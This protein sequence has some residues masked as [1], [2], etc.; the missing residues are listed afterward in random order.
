[1]RCQVGGF[2]LHAGAVARADQRNELERL[3]RYISRPAES[4][5]GQTRTLGIAFE[6]AL[7]FQKAPHALPGELRAPWLQQTDV[8]ARA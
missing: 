5:L 7:A 6:Q 3:C 2:S 8:Q 1:M 4:E